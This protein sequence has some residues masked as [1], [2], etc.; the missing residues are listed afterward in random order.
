LAI[1]GVFG[2]GY[3][4]L[5]WQ[6][7]LLK[8]HQAAE[9]ERKIKI[10]EMR[11]SGQ[12]IEA[13]DCHDIPFGVRAIQSGI[14]VDGIW[15]SNSSTPLPSTLELDPIRRTS[16][17]SIPITNAQ[18]S[19]GTSQQAIG[20]SSSRRPPPVRQTQTDPGNSFPR[21]P[22]SNMG[23]PKDIHILHKPKRSSHL[24]FGSYGEV[25]YDE[26]TLNQLEGKPSSKSS[27]VESQQHMQLV[28][29]VELALGTGCTDRVSGS[30]LERTQ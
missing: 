14:R 17:L 30:T 11:R 3:G 10:A 27:M 22:I 24:R 21:K 8:K 16:D 6:N 25:P 4:K 15:V 19:M 1:L 5:A 18:S 28:K 29:G 7:R 20:G 26:S 2:I 23:E 9:E 13:Q 12:I